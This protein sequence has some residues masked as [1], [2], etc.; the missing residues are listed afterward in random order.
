MNV[1]VT[2]RITTSTSKA[3]KKQKKVGDLDEVKRLS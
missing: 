2:T 1:G 3:K